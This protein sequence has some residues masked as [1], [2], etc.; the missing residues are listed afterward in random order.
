VEGYS[1]ETAKLLLRKS[2]DIAIIADAHNRSWMG[3]RGVG[4]VV[5]QHDGQFGGATDWQI[6]IFSTGN[7]VCVRSRQLRF[8]ECADPALDNRVGLFC[9]DLK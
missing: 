8:L 3:W 4:E 1:C 5:E 9:D 6:G 7:M 2:I